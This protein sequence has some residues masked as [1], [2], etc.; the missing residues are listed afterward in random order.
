MFQICGPFEGGSS[1]LFTTEDSQGMAVD[2]NRESGEPN[3]GNGNGK[4]QSEELW[5]IEEKR[6]KDVL[7]WE[8]D[9]KTASVKD[10][11]GSRSSIVRSELNLE[12]NSVFTVSTYRKKSRE[13]IFAKE[14]G[15]GG[16]I[17]ERRAI[18]GKTA[19]GIETGILTTYHFKV[20]LALLDLWE[21][22]DRPVENSMA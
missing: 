5:D 12:Q 19:G 15:P 1:R 8:S 18:I 3:L 22:A 20:Y 21:K 7:G 10:K 14:T 2:V 17:H 9:E 4:V 13:I 16:E 6:P 11:D